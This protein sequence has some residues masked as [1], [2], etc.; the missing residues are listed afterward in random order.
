[1]S[2]R[3]KNLIIFL[4]LGLVIAAIV[5]AVNWKL[6]QPVAQRLCDGTFVSSVLLLGMGGLKY[7][8]N[9]GFFDV[10]SYGISYTI[11]TVIPS[12]GPMQDEDLFSYKERKKE[13]RKPARDMI[14]AG[15]AYLVLSGILFVIY[16]LTI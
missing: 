3:I 16:Q 2:E 6:E 10:A 14:L 7:V 4:V 8:R 13:G 9:Q 12:M 11:H 5:V 15:C 1:M